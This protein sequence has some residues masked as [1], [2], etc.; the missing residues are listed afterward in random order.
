MKGTIILKELLVLRSLKLAS[1][2]SEFG[3]AYMAW[4]SVEAMQDLSTRTG[5]LSEV[6]EVSF[7]GGSRSK[8]SVLGEGERKGTVS[9]TI[10]LLEWSLWRP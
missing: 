6:Q 8:L 10:S 7:E 5:S 3:P 1:V 4:A 2:A 9:E